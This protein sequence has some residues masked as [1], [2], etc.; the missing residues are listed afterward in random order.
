MIEIM[1]IF[2]FRAR[3]ILKETKDLFR[4]F[5]VGERHV[6]RCVKKVSGAGCVIG[7][8]VV[9]GAVNKRPQVANYRVKANVN[10]V[11]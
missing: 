5:R 10:A 4:E 1:L 9:F 6:R 3:F 2:L 11:A 7:E 8:A